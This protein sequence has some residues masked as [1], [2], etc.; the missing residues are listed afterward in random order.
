MHNGV[1]TVLQSVRLGRAKLMSTLTPW[2]LGVK[3]AAQGTT[4]HS[5]HLPWRLHGNNSAAYRSATFWQGLS[6]ISTSCSCSLQW[7]CRF[8]N[9]G[10]QL[11][12]RGCR[13]RAAASSTLAPDQ[14][15]TDQDVPISSTGP[16][17]SGYNFREIEA[18]WR[19]FW[20]E[21]KTFRT[22]DLSDLDTSK[23]KFYALDM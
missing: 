3:G 5:C 23:P 14:V 17:Q 7:L 15:Q 19:H 8:A 10:P 4:A 9:S 20:L 2:P 18:K 12:P 13:H 11:H 16:Q 21:N 22:P 1:T 6:I